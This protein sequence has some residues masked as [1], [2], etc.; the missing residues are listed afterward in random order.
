MVT[1]IPSS[2][3]R[4][5]NV[6]TVLLSWEALIPQQDWVSCETTLVASRNMS[7]NFMAVSM[8]PWK[9][10]ASFLCSLIVR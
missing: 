1:C 2:E 3:P 5:F 4:A 10:T 8:H 7:R 9:V 6:I